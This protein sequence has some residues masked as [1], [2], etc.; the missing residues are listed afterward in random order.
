MWL[1]SLITSFEVKDYLEYASPPTSHQGL[2]Y[3]PRFC[4]DI[5]RRLLQ[6]ACAFPRS[7]HRV[8]TSSSTL[9]SSSLTSLYHG[10]GFSHLAAHWREEA[11]G[12]KVSRCLQ[13]L[14]FQKGQMYDGRL[15]E[16]KSSCRSDVVWV[17]AI[18]AIRVRIVWLVQHL[19][20]ARDNERTAIAHMLYRIRVSNV[21]TLRPSDRA[22]IALLKSCIRCETV[23]LA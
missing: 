9:L 8:V 14:S 5:E 17:Q 20:L 10:L 16:H 18:A 21:S 22:I 3:P 6:F 7:H 19:A 1:V 13:L 4:N 15:R 11:A 2:F 12:P 23:C